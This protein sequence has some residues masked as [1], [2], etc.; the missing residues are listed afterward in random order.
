MKNKILLVALIGMFLTS[1]ILLVGCDALV[2]SMQ[3]KCTAFNGCDRNTTKCA[4]A[5]G[6]ADGNTYPCS[7]VCR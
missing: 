4:S 2:N 1:G 3:G 5:C 6:G 7:S